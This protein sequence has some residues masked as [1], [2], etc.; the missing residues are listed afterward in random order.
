M[1]PEKVPIQDPG[2]WGYVGLLVGG[3]V[4][5]VAQVEGVSMKWVVGLSGA[6]ILLLLTV[7]GS[8]SLLGINSIKGDIADVKSQ[9]KEANTSIFGI[10][11]EM[12]ASHARVDEK[13]KTQ[14]ECLARIEKEI[15]KMRGV[16][17]P[18]LG[19]GEMGD[20]K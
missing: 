14:D 18:R 5:R 9:V 6:I 4:T 3:I 10:R 15:D 8:L 2:I 12:S 7:I 20:G 19:G 1:T 13:N 16:K 11:V 17:I